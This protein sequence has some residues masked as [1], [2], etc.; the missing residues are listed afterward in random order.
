MQGPTVFA[1]RGWISPHPLSEAPTWAR[2]EPDPMIELP[3]GAAIRTESGV[4]T[5]TYEEWLAV[6]KHTN[7]TVGSRAASLNAR[8]TGSAAQN[9]LEAS[10]E[11]A[12]DGT[13]RRNI[14]V[15]ESHASRPYAGGS[16]GVR[17]GE[18]FGQGNYRA[19]TVEAESV[20]GGRQQSASQRGYLVR[21]AASAVTIQD[22]DGSA[23]TWLEMPWDKEGSRQS[24]KGNG[25]PPWF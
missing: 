2:E 21:E 17:A 12:R 11:E 4:E 16:C 5:M 10:R 3:T 6:Q 1:G 9:H 25:L 13:G 20:A 7:S 15:T 18:P 22:E 24:D 19:P 14:S 23:K 8:S